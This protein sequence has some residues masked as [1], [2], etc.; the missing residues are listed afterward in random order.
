M[1][2][3]S[4]QHYRGTVDFLDNIS[5]KNNDFTSLPRNHKKIHWNQQKPGA[6]N[7]K[8]WIKNEGFN[9]TNNEL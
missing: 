3:S 2:F 4:L 7:R 5:E 1:Q 8:I 9:E 6:Y